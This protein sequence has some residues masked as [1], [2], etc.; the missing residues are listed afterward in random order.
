MILELRGLTRH[1]GGV[2]AVDG[3]DLTLAEGELLG[4]IGPNG[5]GKTTLLDIV[6]GFQLAQSGSV[7]FSGVDVTRAPAHRRAAMGVARTFQAARLFRGLTVLENVVAG[8][9]PR[10]RGDALGH[11]VAAPATGRA[12]R[13]REEEAH[14][15]LARVGL[16]GSPRRIAGGLAYGDQRRLEV[17][18]ALAL[19]PALLLLDEPVAGMNVAETAGI[20]AL[21]EDLRR[22]RLTMVLVEHHL[23][24]VL[25]LCDR[26]VVLD[27]G[28]VIAAGA[29]D[30]VVRDPVVAQAYLGRAAGEQR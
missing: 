25:G 27:F 29:P 22:G 9:H 30:D 21:L 3:V 7:V 15:L 19:R 28:R 26:V 11:I 14:A 12:R 10:R 13:A 18:R 6:S 4:L 1:F 20:R 23:E 2:H 24:F 5:A 16:V 17:A 8:M